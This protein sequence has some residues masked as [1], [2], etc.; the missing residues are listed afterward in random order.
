[1][2]LALAY[3]TSIVTTVLPTIFLIQVLKPRFR[4]WIVLLAALFVS[5]VLNGIRLAPN[6]DG[7]LNGTLGGINFL[8]LAVLFPFVCFRDAVWRRLLFSLI[9][10]TLLVLCDGALG[11]IF[12]PIYGTDFAAFPSPIILAYLFL[13]ALSYTVLAAFCAVA[14]KTLGKGRFRLYYFLFILLPASQ[15]LIVVQ[16]FFSLSNLFLLGGILLGIAADLALFIFAV[17]RD[18]SFALAERLQAVEHTMELEQQYYESLEQEQRE[19]SLFRHDFNNHLAVIHR[20]IAVGDTASANEM[21]QSLSDDLH[22][23]A[24]MKYCA[25]AVFGSPTPK[26]SI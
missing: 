11:L 5:V 13:F 24:P 15:Y 14:A 8:I 21:I 9:F 19:L 3:I 25:N 22:D 20:L 17:N 2:Q 4:P 1:M 16:Y 26:A 10:H 7:Y 23:A 12:S 18:E 6:L